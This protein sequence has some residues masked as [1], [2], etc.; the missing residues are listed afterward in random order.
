VAPR[1]R[2]GAEAVTDKEKVAEAIWQEDYKAAW[3]WEHSN[4][5]RNYYRLLADAAINALDAARS[6]HMP[7]DERILGSLV[8]KWP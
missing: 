3:P 2:L 6:E 5:D 4:T 7:T 1:L 8:P